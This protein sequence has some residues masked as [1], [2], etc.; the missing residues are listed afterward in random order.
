MAEDVK[1]VAWRVTIQGYRILIKR[2]KE[3]RLKYIKNNL[4][5]IEYEFVD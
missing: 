3:K 1:N 4:K 2:H 5:I